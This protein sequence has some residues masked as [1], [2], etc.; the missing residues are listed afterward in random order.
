MEEAKKMC[1]DLIIVHV[2]TYKDG[3]SEPKYHPNP[4][5]TSYK[6]SLDLYR[7]E[8]V[9]IIEIF[10]SALP[11]AEIEKAS[12]DEAFIDFTNPVR[13][14]IIERY[15]ELVLSHPDD[16]DAPLP[17]PPQTINWNSSCN[18]IPIEE[19]EESMIEAPTQDSPKPEP[20]KREPPPVT[21]HDI[22]LSIGGELMLMARDAIFN[23]LGYTTSAVSLSFPVFLVKSN[24]VST[25]GVARNKFLA[26]YP[27]NFRASFVTP[28][29][30]AILRLCLFKR[31]VL[32]LGVENELT[33]PDP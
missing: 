5:T 19:E 10:K 33:C 30:H 21:W 31:S 24:L 1:P 8:S 27:M 26:K 15:P 6:V 2:A 11:T 28:R 29:F 23:Q 22:A 20:V 18:L 14:I 16:L 13:Q 4:D 17:S 7:R 3:E 32:L 9:K 12:V 25:Q